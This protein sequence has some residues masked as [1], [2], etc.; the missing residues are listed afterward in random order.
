MTHAKSA[1]A[2][3]QTARLA[4]RLLTGSM[5]IAALWW[6]ASSA[7]AQVELGT[8]SVQSQQ[9]QRLKVVIPY[10]SGPG[11]P[12]SINRFSVESAT[13]ADGRTIDP[14]QFTMMA[15]LNRNYL[16]VQ[17]RSNV[18]SPTVKLAMNVSNTGKGPQVMDLNVPAA[19][20]AAAEAAPVAA[21]KK[22]KGK[23]RAIV[24]KKRV[25][26]KAVPAK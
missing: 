8:A 26:K 7:Q 12:V 23:K 5:L 13:L 14:K 25:M 16:V 18:Y 22:T 24:K 6:V 1:P 2:L 15:P 9:G 11:E 4:K 3:P 20:A 10:G 17:S 21:V 19:K